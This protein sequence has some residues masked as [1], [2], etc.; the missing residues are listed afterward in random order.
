MIHWPPIRQWLQRHAVFLTGLG[1]YFIFFVLWLGVYRPWSAWLG[2]D[3][4]SLNT[5]RFWLRDG[6]FTH[7]G[8]FL[9]QG[10]SSFIKLLEQPDLWHHAL[11]SVRL[12]DG[13]IAQSI[14][15]NHYPTQY[16]LPLH[17]VSLLLGQVRVFPLQLVQLVISFGAFVRHTYRE[18]PLRHGRCIPKYYRP[19]VQTLAPPPWRFS[20]AT[21]T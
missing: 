12:E 20:G 18:A 3:Y 10:Y 13:A 6:F 16:L 11:S 8:L 9:T 19:P 5:L 2:G 15:Y 14:Y 21:M 1:V 17:W 7:F 4:Q